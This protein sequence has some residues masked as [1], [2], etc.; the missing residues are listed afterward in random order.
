MNYNLL[1]VLILSY[2]FR[3]IVIECTLTPKSPKTK[4]NELKSDKVKSGPQSYSVFD[5]NLVVENPSYKDILINYQAYSKN[6]DNYNINGLVLGYITPV[7]F[8]FVIKYP[9]IIQ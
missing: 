4:K 6:V 3:N 9:N 2:C 7:S 5:R 8:F 1:L